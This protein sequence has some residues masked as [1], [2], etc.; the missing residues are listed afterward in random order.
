MS[1]YAGVEGIILTN[2]EGQLQYTSLDNNVTFIITPKLLA[3]A[4]MARS[5]VRDI[6]PTDNLISL[7]LRTRQ[8]EI[9]VVVPKDGIRVIAMQKLNLPSRQTAQQPEND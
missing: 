8:K 5:A 3:F 1:A 2:E 4:E 9:M 7:R 6:C